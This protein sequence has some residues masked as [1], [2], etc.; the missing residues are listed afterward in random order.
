MKPALLLIDLQNDFLNAPSLI[1][2]FGTIVDKSAQ[3]LDH[4]RSACIP[5]IH[6]WTT[7][8]RDNRMPHWHDLD[9][10]ICVEGTE[11]HSTPSALQP[12][13]AENI[14]HK[15]FFSSFSNVSLLPLLKE[16]GID[17]L[18]MAG[19]HLHGCVRSTVLDAYQNGFVSLVASDAVGSDDP[20]HAAT[21]ARYLESRAASF[22]STDS[23]CNLIA[24][25]GT[26][27]PR[28]LAAIDHR[29]ANADEQ[30]GA[31]VDRG[32]VGTVELRR[33]GAVDQIVQ[34][35]PVKADHELW[36]MPYT[37]DEQLDRMASHARDAL[38][39]WRAVSLENRFAVLRR[40]GELLK[41]HAEELILMMAIDIGKPVSY[42][43]EEI[44]RTVSLLEA[45]RA[46]FND[47]TGYKCGSDI[48][49]RYRPLG[50]VAIITP[51]N[52]PVAIPLGK[53]GPALFYGNAVLWKPAPAASG[54]SQ[55]LMEI[56]SE[57]GLPDGLVSLVIGDKS[58]A[59]QAMRHPGVDA[60]T[61][62][63]SIQAGFAAQDVCSTRYIP[64][65]A[66]LGGNNAAIVWDDCDLQEAAEKV[67][68]SA[69]GFGGQRC[70]ANRR[71]IVADQSFDEFF[72]LLEQATARL[73]WGDPLEQSTQVGPLVCHAKC[74]ELATLVKRA[75]AGGAQ[76]L[77]P[78][79]LA[80]DG[81]ERVKELA[82]GAYFPPT[83]IVCD[84]PKSEIVQE[85]SFGPILVVQRARDWQHAI[86]L[87][88]G[89]KQGLVASL[90]SVSQ[91]LQKDFLEN[92][93]SGILKINSGTS[94]AS[95][96]APFGGWKSSGIG[97]PEHG[98]SNREFY[99]RTQ[100]VYGVV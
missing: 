34:M 37:S 93:D 40:I 67:A 51:W 24:G 83:I 61:I 54:I 48:K 4:C 57:A 11:G 87:C 63:G 1:P 80:P 64:L 18:I 17:T 62:S 9:K 29:N 76:V 94:N 72:D 58:T 14:I 16:S 100:S 26:S 95:A 19:V 74:Q 84:D 60:V 31:T 3:L 41:D 22:Y 30:P 89:V 10:L 38:K 96:E 23:L 21:T 59:L 68:E 97:P 8:S 71:V 75:H 46:R 28:S 6:V 90:F 27:V 55:R 32:S 44:A 73:V 47:L 81:Y 53:I 66:E 70:T 77:S 86:A 13:P 52:N 56:F 85:E 35:S 65:Q 36:R 25:K 98:A 99:T 2:A 49:V 42:S 79:I 39:Q 92:A 69:F 5:V 33:L 12:L 88:N 43:R 45:L 50:T 20:L 15:T 7:A 82:D 91:E 78:H